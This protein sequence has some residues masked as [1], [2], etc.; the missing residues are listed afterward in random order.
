MWSLS[1]PAGAEIARSTHQHRHTILSAAAAAVWL[2]LGGTADAAEYQTVVTAPPPIADRG[3]L[4]EA[5][6]S[7]VITADR[8]PRS[9]EDLPRLLGELPGVTVTRFGGM[10]TLATLSLRG[11][12]AN[13]V[14]VYFDG[15]PLS[16][17]SGGGVDI[18]LFPAVDLGTVEVYRGM[19]PIAFGTSAIGGIVSL[20]TPSIA[21]SGV[22]LYAGSGSFGTYSGGVQSRWAG[23][24]V[25]ALAS[26]NGVMSAGDFPY[27]NDK[28]TRLTTD[29]GGDDETARRQN[30]DFRQN[31]SLLHVVGLLPGRRQV[32]GT[33]SFLHRDQGVPPPGTIQSTGASLTTDRLLTTAAYESRDDLGLSSQ[34]RAQVYNVVTWQRLDDYYGDLSGGARS[35]TRD[36]STS[37][38]ATLS[39]SKAFASWL[40]LSAVSSARIERFRPSNLAADGPTTEPGERRFLAGGLESAFAIAPLRLDATPSLR[41][42]AAQDSIARSRRYRLT[43][44]QSRDADTLLWNP[45]LTLVQ[46][47]SAEVSLR[48]NLGRYG[49]LP[50]QLE[51]YGNTGRILGNPDLVPEKGTNADVGAHWAHPGERVRVSLDA[52]LFAVWARD[53]IVFRQSGGFYRPANLGRARVLGGE[54]SAAL[55]WARHLR[56]FG[57]VTLTDARNQEDV[58]GSKDHQIPHRPRLRAYAR[59]EAMNLPIWGRW[60]WGLYADVDVTGGNYQDSANQVRTP[61]RTLF[62]AGG[63]LEAPHWGLRLLASAYNLS[64]SQIVDLVGYPLPGRSV[65]FTL[66]WTL[67]E[68]HKE[69]LE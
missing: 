27:R 14:E 24:R 15:V 69:N 29:S 23:R 25:R 41:V 40:R 65:F 36:V 49:R 18:S 5:A 47:P 45:R 32:W 39:A 57:Q 33:A 61:A 31:D 2:C 51:R 26:L 13:Q 22:R 7:S 56:L 63:H 8:T 52:A 37:T 67:S 64:N 48:A 35:Q 53:L 30:N 38:G 42:E 43:G 17:A 66:Q 1:V 50:S 58:S 4:D 11:S 3:R 68:P 20:G 54:A 16:A 6:S 21:D 44:E 19:S 59:P 9:A 28:G 12:S 10:G 60:R 46:R 34:W 55:E 62:G